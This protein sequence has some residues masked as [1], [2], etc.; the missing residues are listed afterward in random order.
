MKHKFDDSEEIPG[1][2]EGDHPPK[3]PK[4]PLKSYEDKLW[5]LKFA[6]PFHQH[7]SR[8]YG[9]NLESSD[10]DYRSCAGPG[11]RSV[12]RIK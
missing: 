3:R 9:V 2:E 8:K 7:D 12:A 4:H 5:G 1:E 11:W 6:C 10:A